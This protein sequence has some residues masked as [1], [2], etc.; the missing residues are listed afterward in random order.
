MREGLRSP[1]LHFSMYPSML[2]TPT[3]SPSYVTFRFAQLCLCPLSNNVS[4][5]RSRADE[6]DFMLCLH[7]LCLHSLLLSRLPFPAFPLP[8]R[9]PS[10]PITPFLFPIFLLSFLLTFLLSF[11]A[12]FLLF[13]FSYFLPSFPPSLPSFLPSISL[14]S[15]APLA[16]FCIS[17]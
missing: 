11:L 6:D 2:L 5:I 7:F 3:A 9:I 15:I 8:S 14:S 4:L 10:F 16:Y 17:Y 12:S 13:P 1:R